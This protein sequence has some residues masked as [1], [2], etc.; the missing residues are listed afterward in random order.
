M[1]SMRKVT[2]FFPLLFHGSS[3]PQP[4]WKDGIRP[5]V[6]SVPP[7]EP[8]LSMRNETCIIAL[9][10]RF[11]NPKAVFTGPALPSFLSKFFSH[12]I[13]YAT[14]KVH[15]VNFAPFFSLPSNSSSQFILH[16]VHPH[17]LPEALYNCH[18][19][20]LVAGATG[21]SILDPGCA[22][23]TPNVLNTHEPPACELTTSLAIGC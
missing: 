16:F 4:T 8:A 20:D 19:S 2:R 9:F 10:G 15:I 5:R 21:S 17:P 23:F 6:T 7:T 12:Y 11:F 14:E 22:Q 18:C 13:L 3:F 1:K